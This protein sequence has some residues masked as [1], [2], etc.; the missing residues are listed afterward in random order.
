MQHIVTDRRRTQ[1]SSIW[2]YLRES[3]EEVRNRINTSESNTPCILPEQSQMGMRLQEFE[4]IDNRNIIRLHL[5]HALRR[6]VR[7]VHVPPPVKAEGLC[8]K[9]YSAHV[10]WEG[11]RLHPQAPAIIV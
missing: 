6:E 8:E 3:T 9:K 11:Q 2:Q 7:L 10:T 1:P 4:F 5:H